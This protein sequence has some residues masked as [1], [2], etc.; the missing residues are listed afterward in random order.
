MR[1]WVVKTRKRVE[2]LFLIW[3]ARLIKLFSLFVPYH[4]GVWAGGAFGFFSYYLLY[5]ERKRTI[6]HLTAIFAAK[7]PSWIRCTARRS[8]VHLGKAVL[9]FA[10]ITPDRLPRVFDFHGEKAVSRA[11][12]QGKGAIYV[13]GHL[14]NWELM[15]YS[16]VAHGFPLSVIAAP[17]RPQQLND[18]ITE[19]RAKMGVKTI[20][21]GTS[22]AARELIRIFKENRVLAVLID[23]D[24]DVEGAFVD[25]MGRMAW[26]PTGAVSMAIKFGAPI[27]FGHT[28]RGKRNRHTGT[29]ETIDLIR[30]GNDEKDIFV[31]TALLT[32]KIE[33]CVRRN[34]EQWVWMH[35]RWR[36][37]P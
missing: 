17:I 29:I 28:S 21:R 3:F 34:P 23:Q 32:K 2:L 7:D 11:L 31:N 6:A 24:T 16:G 12:R 4:L 5:R 27:L 26:T 35:R 18:M 8:F 13:T 1:D 20:V 25:F 19:I 14:G 37:Q 22:G 30:T 15:A 10:L 9:E 33:D 36:T